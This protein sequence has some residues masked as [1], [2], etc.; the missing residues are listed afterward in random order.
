MKKQ[1]DITATK[2]FCFVGISGKPGVDGP[3]KALS[4]ETLSGKI[5]SQVEA[6]LR[7]APDNATFF[8]DNL[9]QNPPLTNGKLRYPSLAELKS[10]WHS[11]EIRMTR[12]KSNIVI[13]LG[14]I[15]ADFFKDRRSIRILDCPSAD[16]RFLK[17]AGVDENG[18]LV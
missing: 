16:G 12:L 17:W 7:T 13:L 10:E 18:V 3:L 11:F 6:K 15:V 5:I 2:R 14:K 1:K 4:D 9:V 8:R